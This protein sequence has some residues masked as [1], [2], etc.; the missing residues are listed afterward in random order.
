MNVLCLC[1]TCHQN[2][3]SNPLD[4]DSWV[5]RYLGQGHVDLLNEKRRQI[6][7][8]TAESRKEI[9]A[10]YNRQ[11]KLLE[12]DPSHQLESFQ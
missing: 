12:A 5:R 11:I 9:T 2:F 1:H 6:F 7:K 10:H 8:T 3:T 4:F